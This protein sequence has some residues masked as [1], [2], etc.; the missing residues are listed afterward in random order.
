MSQ[1]G[2][3]YRG[4]AGQTVLWPQPHQERLRAEH[5]VRDSVGRRDQAS[6]PA[7]PADRG[8]SGGDLIEDA[9]RGLAE[10]KLG[11]YRHER[12]KLPQFHT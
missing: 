10:M 2:E 12:L 5:L 8:V 9:F 6:P 1:V 4:L 7:D 11:G 3:R